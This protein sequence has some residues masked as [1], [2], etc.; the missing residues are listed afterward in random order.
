MNTS[1]D[2]L[3]F[4]S[5]HASVPS[6]VTA[7]HTAMS[8]EGH[9]AATL[10]DF[11]VLPPAPGHVYR[12]QRLSV[13]V[14][15]TVSHTCS[16]AVRIIADGRAIFD[17]QWT[18]ATPSQGVDIGVLMCRELVIQVSCSLRINAYSTIALEGVK[19]VID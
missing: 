2:H 14:G 9:D 8:L 16:K 3:F 1:I 12:L 4:S 18:S 5:G 13:K 17:A 15:G 7:L 19:Y 6:P 11:L 10:T